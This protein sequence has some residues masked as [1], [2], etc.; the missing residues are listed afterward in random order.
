MSIS[1]DQSVDPHLTPEHV[2][3]VQPSALGCEDCMKI[4]SYWVHLRICTECG[5][6]EALV[7][8]YISQLYLCHSRPPCAASLAWGGRSHLLR[9]L[10]RNLQLSHAWNLQPERMIRDGGHAR[11]EVFAHPCQCLDK[12]HPRRR[13]Y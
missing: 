11:Q 7:V 6:A 12:S 9:E 3:D 4:G 2:R 10:R 5:H 1:P 13:L 8:H